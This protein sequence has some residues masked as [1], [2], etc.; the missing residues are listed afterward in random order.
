MTKGFEE[1]GVALEVHLSEHPILVEGS[2]F[3]NGFDV[4]SS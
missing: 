3:G 4:P 2:G 1:V